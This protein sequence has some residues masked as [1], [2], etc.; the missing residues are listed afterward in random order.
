MFNYMTD[1]DTIEID[2]SMTQTI[3]VEGHD[4][5]SLLFAFMDEI[6][7]NFCADFFVVK[8]C[9]ITEFDMENFKIKAE[10]WVFFFLY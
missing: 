2:E 1:A 5:C 7:F 3:E 4:L 8:E 6:L 10:T 9:R